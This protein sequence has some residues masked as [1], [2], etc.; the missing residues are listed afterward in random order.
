MTRQ[1]MTIL[2]RVRTAFRNLTGRSRVESDLDAELKSYVE[3]LAAEKVKA[4]MHPA[5][6]RRAAVIEVGGVERVKD[7][8][9]DERPGQVLENALRDLRHGARLL[10]RAPGFSTIAIVT[11]ALGIG[12]TSAIFSV[13]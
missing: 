6:A 1:S 7:D 5:D 13:L 2:T 8:V 3:L 4:G 9:R 11:I 10:R 12:A